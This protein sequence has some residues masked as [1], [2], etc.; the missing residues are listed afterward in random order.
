MVSLAQ[1]EQF[2]LYVEGNT[3]H[4]HPQVKP[5]ADPYLV[6]WD[7]QNLYSNAI[8]LTTQRSLTFAKDIVVVV[9]SW[10]SASEKS[11]TK[12]APSGAR[13]AAIASGKAEQFS[14]VIPNLSEAEAQD[15]ANRLRAQLTAH[16][17]LFEF[18]EPADLTLTARNML[19]L[20]GTASTWDTVYWIDSIVRSMSLESG[21]TMSVKGKNVPTGS[22][23]LAT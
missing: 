5:D 14:Y 15:T 7:K 6:I 12:Y 23:V 19:K 9:R 1:H 3:V 2:D 21:F 17:R 4:F 13:S 16:E 11:I 18:S 10:N 8:T 22:G 20:Q